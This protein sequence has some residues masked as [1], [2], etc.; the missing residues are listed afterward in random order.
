MTRTGAK[1]GFRSYLPRFGSAE[2]VK[3]SPEGRATAIRAVKN[4]GVERLRRR[5][6]ARQLR[7]SGDDGEFFARPGRG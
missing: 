2:A 4:Q 7:H 3:L 6:A 1:G 5:Y